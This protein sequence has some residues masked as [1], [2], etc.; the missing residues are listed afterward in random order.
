M[1]DERVETENTAQEKKTIK[2]GGLFIPCLTV[3]IASFCIMVIELIAG[4]ILARYLGASLYTWTSVIGIVLLGIAVGNYFGGYLADRFNPKK[5]I[6]LFC[7]LGAVSCILVPVLN[8]FAGEFYLFWLLPWPARI[9]LHIVLVFLLPSAALGVILPA[10]TKFALDYGLLPGRTVGDIY[11]WSAVGSIAGTFIAGFLLIPNLKTSVIL[12]SVSF[13]LIGVG[14][15]Y[16]ARIGMSFYLTVAF[17]VLFAALSFGPQKCTLGFAQQLGLREPLDPLV[18]YQKESA[19]S[20]IHIRSMQD[21]PNVRRLMLN[22]LLHSIVDTNAPAD[23]QAPFQYPYLKLYAAVTRHLG[24]ESMRTL[25]IGGGG[26]VFPRYIQENWPE[27]SI[28]VVEIDPEVTRAA[29]EVLGLSKDSSMR[30]HHMDACNFVDDTLR[31]KKEQAKEFPLYDFIY[32]DAISGFAVPYQLT[33]SEFNEKIKGLLTPKGVYMV[34]IIDTLRSGRFLGAMVNTLEE[35]FAKVK[36]FRA[37]TLIDSDYARNTFTILCSKNPIDFE[38]MGIEETGNFLMQKEELAFIRERVGAMVLS[39]DYA[40]VDSLLEPV[41]HQSGL[42]I[43]SSRLTEMGNELV[44]KEDLNGAVGYYRKALDIFPEFFIAQNNLG[45][46]LMQQGEDEEALSYFTEALRI[47]PSF[48]RTHSNLAALLTKQGKFQEAEGEYQK[49]LSLQPDSA[50]T[51]FNFAT[52]LAIQEKPEEA[53]QEYRKAIEI[54]P[55]F[56]E[57][58]NSLGNL[59]A[60]Q[61]NSEEALVYYTQALRIRPDYVQVHNNIGVILARQ[62]KID[63]AIRH[64]QEAL[65]INPDYQR[66][67][68]NL[69]AVL[70]P[71]EA[72][73]TYNEVAK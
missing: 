19:Y 36:V 50:E 35:S 63:E 26:Y 67:R 68:I 20:Y 21:H 5:I 8:K 52:T 39:D 22:Q 14:A 24:G 23:I 30:I 10:I 7:I 45:N 43:A 32:C 3:F 71:K 49:A 70:A 54:R 72:N 13:I 44:K 42:Q 11:A 46:I 60:S 58:H 9:T 64:Y 15:A 1:R 17:F 40:P 62:G 31:R 65:R 66:A 28:D 51:L 59:F 56:A 27:S 37:E 61:G 6:S 48:A 41:V 25:V 34:T 73:N 33:T 18:L 12:Y 53:I 2:Q 29:V 55:N 16:S 47:N 57:A 69:E 4:R 38:N